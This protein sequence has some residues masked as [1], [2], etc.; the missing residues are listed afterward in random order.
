VTLSA[1][2][3]AAGS[4]TRFENGHKLLAEID[5][6][7]LVRHVASALAQSSVDDIILI[8]GANAADIIRAAGSGR[9]QSIENANTAEGLSSSLC[10]GIRNID[11][12]SN[13]VLI[14]LG[15]MPGISV[16]LI[17]TLLA[18]FNESNGH[19]I[20]FPVAK[21]GRRGHPVVWPR[22]LFPALAA[23]SG[24]TGGK[25]LLLENRSL[26]RPVPYDDAGAFTDID[27]RSD[28]DAFRHAGRETTRRR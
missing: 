6:V 8:T 15:D 19:S 2:I 1:I 21:D 25:T 7:P 3:L 22:A 10:L 12:N 20:V 27:T 13:G 24:D 4:S 26:W 18:A 17:D 11:E 9:W 5:G 16:E 14:A 28:L 23:L